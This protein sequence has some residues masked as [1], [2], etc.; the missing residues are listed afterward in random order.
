MNTDFFKYFQF[1]FI[2]KMLFGKKTYIPTLLILIFKCMYSVVDRFDVFDKFIS[3]S[4][5]TKPMSKIKEKARIYFMSRYSDIMCTKNN[6][7]SSNFV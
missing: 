6:H 4:Y 5:T 7:N 1:L 2:F 3:H